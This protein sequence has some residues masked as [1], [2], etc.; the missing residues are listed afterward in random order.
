MH[1]TR[2]QHS[3][4]RTIWMRQQADIVQRITVHHEQVS[5]GTRRHDAETPGI[6]D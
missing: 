6:A 3:P 1:P 5:D 2:L 4:D